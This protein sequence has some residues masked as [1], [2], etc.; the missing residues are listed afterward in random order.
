VLFDAVERRLSEQGIEH[1]AGSIRIRKELAIVFFVEGDTGRLEEPY[2]RV[3]RQRPQNT[4][5]HGRRTT[6]EVT[7]RD[8]AIRDVASAAPADEDLRAGLSCAIEQANAQGR[9]P[10]SREDGCRETG[11]TGADDQDVAVCI[12]HVGIHDIVN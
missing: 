1:V 8:D 9:I 5:D 10:P 11:C 7:F 12:T 2:C 4:A 3:H 6:P